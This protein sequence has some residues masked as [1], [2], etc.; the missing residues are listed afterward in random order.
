MD[1]LRGP[2]TM[3]INREVEATHSFMKVSLLTALLLVS[4][5]T[6]LQPDRAEQL[7]AVGGDIMVSCRY[8]RRMFVFNKKYWCQ[9]ESRHNCVILIS[10]E[11]QTQVKQGRFSALDNRQG[12]FLVR[13][14]QIILSD[15]G[16]YWCAIDKMYADIMSAVRVT[17]QEPVSEPTLMF[18]DS[19]NISCLGLPV[20]ISCSSARGSKV[21]YRWHK[22]NTH[23]DSAHEG[24][25]TFTLQCPHMQDSQAFVCSSF[26]SVS[27]KTSKPVTTQLLP[28][29]QGVCTFHVTLPVT[30][31]NSCDLSAG[32]DYYQC[33]ILEVTTTPLVKTVESMRSQAVV[34]LGT[35]DTEDAMNVSVRCAF[36]A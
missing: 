31:S 22:H 18:L 27:R 10:T 12:L 11:G 16:V 29:A 2:Q 7:V 9:G 24:S 23:M 1:F 35:G 34:T 28:P 4:G 26:N 8:D 25:P 6:E 5:T 14:E 33:P 3:T 20:R 32:G 36:W 21:E 19:P 17:V 15:A 13:M 30:S